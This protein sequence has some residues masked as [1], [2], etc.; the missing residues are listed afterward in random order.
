MGDIDVNNFNWQKNRKESL[1]LLEHFLNNCLN[2]FGNFQT[3]CRKIISIY[4][5]H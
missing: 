5:I 4:F 1:Q 2:D 3:Q